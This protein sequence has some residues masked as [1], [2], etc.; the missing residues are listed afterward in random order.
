MSRVLHENETIDVD[1]FMKLWKEELLTM[2]FDAFS[3]NMK[4]LKMK[5][6]TYSEW[7]KIWVAWSELSSPEDI[8]MMYKGDFEIE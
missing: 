7:V 5:D 1:L 2:P 6:Q 3:N 8:D 4:E